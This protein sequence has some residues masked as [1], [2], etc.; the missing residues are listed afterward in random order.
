MNFPETCPDLWP[1]YQR[2][3]LEQRKSPYLKLNVAVSEPGK[4]PEDPSLPFKSMIERSSKYEE[5][6]LELS[7]SN[8][9]T[10]A[11]GSN[12]KRIQGPHPH[13][14]CLKLTVGQDMVFEVKGGQ[15][16]RRYKNANGVYVYYQEKEKEQSISRSHRR[17]S[18]WLITK[19]R[20]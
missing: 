12:A 7:V 19:C 14:H 13:Q 18:K 9:S 5:A 4:N 16:L 6:L 1:Q 2:R 10:N 15:H 17:K 11:G 3:V 20:N 8:L